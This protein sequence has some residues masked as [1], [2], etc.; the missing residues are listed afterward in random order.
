MK[1]HVDTTEQVGHVVSREVTL[2]DRDWYAFNVLA[3]ARGKVIDNCHL[4]AIGDETP[5]EVGADESRASGDHRLHPVCLPN[6]ELSM[7][8]LEH[9]ERP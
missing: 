9:E 5:D 8:E 6:G 1:D 4:R 2:R 3:A 7:P